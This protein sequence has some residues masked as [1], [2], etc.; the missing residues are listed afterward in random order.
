MNKTYILKKINAALALV[1]ACLAFAHMFLAFKAFYFLIYDAD[2]FKIPAYALAI[3]VSVHAFL[4]IA[5]FFFGHDTSSLSTPKKNFPVIMQRAEAL[6][7]LVLIHRHIT[8][9]HILFTGQ[10]PSGLNIFL[11]LFLEIIF[12]ACVIFHTIESIPNALIRL[13]IL[14]SPKN[15]DNMAKIGPR[16][17]IVSF[18]LLIIYVVGLFKFVFTMIGGF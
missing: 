14:R 4:S 3:A 6:L 8:S 15:L 5:I 9:Y 16:L 17:A 7:M 13:G 12:M 1:T 10:K 18:I 2:T 11:L